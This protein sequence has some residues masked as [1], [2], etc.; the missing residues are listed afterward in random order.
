MARTSQFPD[1]TEETKKLLLAYA[2]GQKVELRLSLRS[3]IILDWRDGLTFQ[4]SADRRNVSEMTINKWRSRFAENGIE[5]LKDSSRTGK[6]TTYSEADKNRVINLACSKPGN[7]KNR[8]SQQ[9]IAEETGISQSKVSIILREADIRPHKTAYWCGK[10]P[11]PDFEA[12]MMEI[13][14]LYL[15]PPSNAMVISVDEKT[16]IQALDRTQPELPLK[17]GKVRR[18]TNTY[19]RNGIVNLMAGLAVHSGEITAE[20]V[21]KNDSETFLK[22]LKKLDRKY[23]NVELHIIMDNLTTHKTRRVKE[24]LNRKRKFHAHYTP[25]YASWL[26]QIEI[27]FNILSRDVLNDGV[28]NSKKQLIDQIMLYIKNYNQEKAKPFQWTYGKNLHN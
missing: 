6:P 4:Q 14:A 10:S 2:R 25:T 8:R 20:T 22:F 5:G 28:W 15:D 26:N 17:K 13:V 18:L 23:R 11:D 3:K 27:F 24:W 21:E 1:T 19:K 9:D 7:G 16:Q 12:K